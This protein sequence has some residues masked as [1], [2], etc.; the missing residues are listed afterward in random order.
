M[1]IMIDRDGSERIGSFNYVEDHYIVMNNGSY[2]T[3]T[4]TVFIRKLV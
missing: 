2:I 1:I 3:L 4:T